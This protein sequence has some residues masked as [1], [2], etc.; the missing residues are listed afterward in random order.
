MNW[1]EFEKR[2]M[3]HYHIED[4]ATVKMVPFE[5]ILGI[6][7]D[8]LSYGNTDGTVSHIDLKECV[9]QFAS[10]WGHEPKTGS[11][12]VVSAVG[13]RFF[14]SRTHTAFYEFFTEG[15]HTRFYMTFKHT[16]LESVLEAVGLNVH[17][18]A[19]SEF[20]SLLN[21]LEAQGYW[22]IDLR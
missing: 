1:Q 3:E 12:N 9:D 16:P 4:E 21:K 6:D 20:H 10:A 22:A 13:G 7:A 5:N 14:S 15:H 2:I 8:T 19:A 18:Q 11:G 17:S